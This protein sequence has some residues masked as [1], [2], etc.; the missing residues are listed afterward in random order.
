[1]PRKTKSEFDEKVTS[2]PMNMDK[3]SSSVKAAFFCG[4]FS[5]AVTLVATV[6]GMAQGSIKYSGMEFSVWT[7]LDVA[8]LGGLTIGL[9]FKSRVCATLMLV[10]FVWCKYV[11]WSSEIKVST[12]VV[13]LAFLYFYAQGVRGAFVFHSL[14]LKTYNQT[15]QPPSL[16]ITPPPAEEPRQP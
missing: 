5:T 6:I 3:A 8:V 14:K 16:S 10:Y 12:V 11:Q 9:F 15:L 13:G 2:Y 4:I 1:M 7:F